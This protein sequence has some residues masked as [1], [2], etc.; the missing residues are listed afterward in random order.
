MVI[1]ISKHKQAEE[2]L[3]ESE[4]KF[5]ALAE[6]APA[7]IVIVAGEDLIYD[8]TDSKLNTN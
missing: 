3:R 4:A 5:R 7:V 8:I 2:A 1:D 6:S